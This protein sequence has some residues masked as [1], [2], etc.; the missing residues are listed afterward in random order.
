MLSLSSFK[1]TYGHKLLRS[2][3]LFCNFC[4]PMIHIR[5]T[6]CLPLCFILGSSLLKVVENYVGSGACIHLPTVY[7]ANAIILLLV[8]EVPNLIV[9]ICVVEVVGFVTKFGDFNEKE[10]NIFGVGAS[11]EKSSCALVVGELLL[12]KRLYV[13]PTTSVDPLAWWQIHETQFPNLRFLV[14]QILGILGS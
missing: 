1:T 5:C 6:I 3:N 14:K 2:S 8:F 11:M 12:F 4:K 7:D 9:Q 13:S 10:R